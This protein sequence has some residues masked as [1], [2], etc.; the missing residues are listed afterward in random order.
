MLCSGCNFLGFN[1]IVIQNG[2]CILNYLVPQSPRPQAKVD[3][4]VSNGE[5]RIEPLKPIEGI[6]ADKQARGSNGAGVAARE[7]HSARSNRPHC[8]G[9][10]EMIM[11][12]HMAVRPD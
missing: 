6:G 12:E 3:I 1:L 8:F 5:V 10:A 2:V 7:Q 4:M 9:N 11:S